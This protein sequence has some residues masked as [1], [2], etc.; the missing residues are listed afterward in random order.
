MSQS[1]RKLTLYRTTIAVL[2]GAHLTGNQQTLSENDGAANGASVMGC[3]PTT[4]TNKEERQQPPP[5]PSRPAQEPRGRPK[6]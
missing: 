3:P 6:G 1:T 2:S 4:N 5:P